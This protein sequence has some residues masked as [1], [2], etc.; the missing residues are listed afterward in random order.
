MQRASDFNPEVLRLFDQFVHGSIDRRGFLNGAAK[1]A[2][3]G[4]T[5]TM[6]LDMLCPR[7][8]QAQQI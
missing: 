8:A 6:L 7:F 2:T 1:Y 5:A 4:V 3:G